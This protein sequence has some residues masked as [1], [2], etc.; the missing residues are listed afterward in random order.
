M[1]YAGLKGMEA[2]DAVVEIDQMIKDVGL[3]DKGSEFADQL[4][5][6]RPLSL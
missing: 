3:S 6:I 4:S 2:S 5:G 1:F